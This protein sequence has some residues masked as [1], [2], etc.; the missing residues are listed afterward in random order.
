VERQVA[1]PLTTAS[2][3]PPP[4]ATVNP[5]QIPLPPKQA[6]ASSEPKDAAKR[7]ELI[8]N[9]V[10]RDVYDGIALV[11]GPHGMIEVIAGE[12]VPG[13]G[14]VKSIERRGLGWIVVTSR[15]TIEFAR[16]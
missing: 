11:E 8:S 6:A 13:I 10:V 16:N 14:A 3:A 1:G 5:A 2:I 9:W 7:P 15:G 4:A 12:T